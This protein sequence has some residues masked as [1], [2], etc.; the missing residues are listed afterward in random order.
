MRGST[1]STVSADNPLSPSSEGEWRSL[2]KDQV[3]F[4]AEGHDTTT[5]LVFG[6]GSRLNR[7]TSGESVRVVAVEEDR[8]TVRPVGGSQKATPIGILF[9][10]PLGSPP[11]AAEAAAEGAAAAS[12]TRA[13]DGRETGGSAATTQ[14]IKPTC[15]TSIYIIAVILMLP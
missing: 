11:A 15:T 4:V 3:V 7:W 10:S 12:S 8:V 5:R 1:A 2:T 6:S 13:E 14:K 9:I